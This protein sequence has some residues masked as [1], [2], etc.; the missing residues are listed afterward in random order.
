MEFFGKA[1]TSKETTAEATAREKLELVV[2]EL[3][4][5]KQTDSDYDEEGYINNRLQDKGMLVVG[6]IVTVDGWQFTIDRSVPKIGERIGKGEQNEQIEINMSVI[7]NKDYSKATVTIEIT[8]EKEIKSIVFNGE[9]LTIPSKQDGKYTVTAEV[10]EN[11]NYTVV[12]KDKEDKFNYKNIQVT[13]LT[14]DMDIWNKEDMETFRNKVNEGRTFEGKKIHVKDDIDLENSQWMSI[15]TETTSFKGEFNGENHTINGLYI[16]KQEENLGLFKA[17]EGTIKNITVKG[18]ITGNGQNIAGIC[19]KNYG[20]IE[21]ATNY[22]NITNQT[23]NG[24]KAAG[25]VG[26][27]T[28]NKKATV[29]NCNNYG[30]INATEHAGGIVGHAEAEGYKI[31]SCHNYGKIITQ[32]KAGGIVGSTKVQGTIENC[33]NES[34]VTTTSKSGSGGILGVYYNGTKAMTIHNCINRGKIQGE[35]WAVGGIVGDAVIINISECEN[36][37]EIFSKRGNVGGILGSMGVDDTQTYTSQIDKC[38]NSG[39]VH[40]TG[41]GGNPVCGGIMGSIQVGESVVISNCYNTGEI[42]STAYE[43][44]SI[45]HGVGGILGVCYNNATA[46]T[47]KSK[48]TISNS[49]NRGNIKNSYSSSNA[50]QII[51]KDDCGNRNIT[52]CYY[53]N[54]VQ[55]SNIN[56]GIALGAVTL[57]GYANT[58]GTAFTADTENINEGYP[59]LKW[60]IG[61]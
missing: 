6:D 2:T 56:G 51:G 28:G 4:M 46:T 31:D 37:G 58:L 38:I 36:E 3:S 52:K 53:L 21:N 61:E 5:D 43:A 14:E 13:Q 54:T 27:L 59:I 9:E 7:P 11:G 24:I 23:T 47:T 57:K 41:N 29:S 1:T 48:A 42:A 60:Q 49:Y 55:G 18:E 16:N 8:Y 25:I 44:G 26:V 12:V 35:V 17:N 39:Y 20:V 19:A 22:A 33:T 10:S 40:A 45:Y 30:E 32:G 15:G 50:G 34:E